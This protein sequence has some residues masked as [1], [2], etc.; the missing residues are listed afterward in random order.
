MTFANNAPDQ[1]QGLLT[2]LTL[3]RP[4]GSATELD[5]NA[6]LLDY[7]NAHPNVIGS[8]EDESGN[9]FASTA[10]DTGTLITCHTDTVHGPQ[11]GPVQQVLYDADMGMAYTNGKTVLGAD[12][13]TGVW[14]A[15]K[16]IEAGVKATFVFYRGEERG[17]IGSSQSAEDAPEFY[18]SFQ[19]AIALDRAGTRDV[20]THQARG[21]CCSDVFAKALS[22]VLNEHGLQFEPCDGGVFTDTANLTHL[23]PECTN[24]SVGY[25][26]QHS[27]SEVQDVAFAQELLAALC[28]IDFSA[29]PTERDPAAVERH[30]F[31]TFARGY[32]LRDG[33]DDV[34]DDARYISALE[35]DE[36]YALVLDDPEYAVELLAVMAHRITQDNKEWLV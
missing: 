8:W 22:A 16:M 20:I 5:F 13:G 21:R 17:G 35:N 7:L 11:D 31:S 34:L 26:G 4:Y 19:R 15:T 27:G 18:A 36:L 33:Y 6:E 32:D 25:E 30:S 1:V 12:D 29:L 10:H 28:Q 23:I 2:I 24:L 9:I 14:L 3:C